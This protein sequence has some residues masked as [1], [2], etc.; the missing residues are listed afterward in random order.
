MRER[1]VTRAVLLTPD[2]EVLLIRIRE[3][4]TGWTAWITPGGGA[5]P[6]ETPAD[7]LRREL[8]EETGLEG[9]EVGPVVWTRDHSDTWE[10]RAFRQ[11]ETFHL[12]RTERFEPTIAHQPEPV[13]LRA[14]RGFKWWTVHEILAS[15]DVFVP[16]RLGEY[17]RDLVENPDPPVPFDAGI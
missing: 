12:V 10:G 7:T 3:S 1:I 8:H 11:I 2:R 14:F 15:Q 17:L 16:L 13:E 4:T 5:R 6:G 9:F